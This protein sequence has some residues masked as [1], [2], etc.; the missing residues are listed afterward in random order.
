MRAPVSHP[1]R[2]C[3]PGR[4]PVGDVASVGE[5]GLGGKRPFGLAHRVVGRPDV[6]PPCRRGA[7]AASSRRRIFFW[8]S[9]GRMS[10]SPWNFGGDRVS[11][12]S[13]VGVAATSGAAVGMGL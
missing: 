6:A 1:A 7:P 11:E 10:R 2:R 13:Q 4:L 8:V 5:L 12:L 9:A 3:R